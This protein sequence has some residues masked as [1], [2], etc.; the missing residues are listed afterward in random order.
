MRFGILFTSFSFFG[1]RCF[2]PVPWEEKGTSQESKPRRL[3]QIF[4]RLFGN[5]TICDA[6][7]AFVEDL[8]AERYAEL[9]KT[10]TGPLE[11][12][13]RELLHDGGERVQRDRRVVV[14]AAAAI[15]ADEEVILLTEARVEEV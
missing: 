15:I 1:C 14:A 9:V 11:Q 13:A 12:H 4:S 2:I 5:A 7:A 10:A 3:A 8:Y 6:E